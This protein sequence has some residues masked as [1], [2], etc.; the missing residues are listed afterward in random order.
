M[1]TWLD[2]EIKVT[3]H[4]SLNSSRGIIRY[5][6]FRDC[7][8]KTASTRSEIILNSVCGIWLG[9]GEGANVIISK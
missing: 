6:D 7:D 5:C 1:T 2:T 4:R 3:Q 9:V 8:D